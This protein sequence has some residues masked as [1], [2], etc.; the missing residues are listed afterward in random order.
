LD[1]YKI[2]YTYPFAENNKEQEQWIENAITE[3]GNFA[4]S[5]I[6]HEKEKYINKK[7]L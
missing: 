4:Q 2:K 6:T 1:S 3:A 7:S 5:N